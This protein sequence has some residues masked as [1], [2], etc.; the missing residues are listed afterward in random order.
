VI[1]HS[2]AEVW[3]D[4]DG[5]P[6]LM[7]IGRGLGRTAR[8]AGQTEH[9]YTVLAHTFV[10]AQLVRPENRIHALLHDAPEAI[11]GDVPTT[12]KTD[13]A[14]AHEADLLER[15]YAANGIDLPR[16]QARGDIEIADYL[17]LVAEAHVLGHAN[18]GWW[19]DPPDER[20]VELTKRALR[21][22]NR[23]E[24]ELRDG[25]NYVHAVERAMKEVAA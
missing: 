7:D 23:H 24:V 1:T 12:W 20:A 17:A 10:V 15:I 2:G 3:P 11:V 16:P 14:R 6:T 13:G 9:L 21:W 8:F 22:S 4:N 5:V 18:P 25:S 19:S